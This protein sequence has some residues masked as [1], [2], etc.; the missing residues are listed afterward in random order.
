MNSSWR[1]RY[2]TQRRGPQELYRNNKKRIVDHW[3]AGSGHLRSTSAETRLT[4]LQQASTTISSRYLTHHH[5]FQLLD[6]F[7]RGRPDIRDRCADTTATCPAAKRLSIR[8]RDVII[9][10]HMAQHL[11]MLGRDHA[12]LQLRDVRLPIAVPQ[13]GSETA[14]GAILKSSLTYRTNVRTCVGHSRLVQADGHHWK[15]SFRTWG[16]CDL[17]EHAFIS[18]GSSVFSGV[19]TADMAHI[20]KQFAYSL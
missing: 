19:S 9:R 17:P 8:C 15:H 2:W 13:R 20:H 12:C 1:Q 3:G 5:A 14:S 7:K 11:N 18:S 4:I 16:W 6:N 10:T